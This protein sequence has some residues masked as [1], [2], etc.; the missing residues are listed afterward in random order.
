MKKRTQKMERK[1]K[2]LRKK[3]AEGLVS[4]YY[5]QTGIPLHTKD[6]LDE[7]D[8]FVEKLN[9]QNKKNTEKAIKSAKKELKKKKKEIPEEAVFV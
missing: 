1:I 9:K 7:A 2:S 4:D 8:K 3:Y 6:K 5:M